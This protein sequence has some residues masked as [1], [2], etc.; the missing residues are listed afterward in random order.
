[1]VKHDLIK[2]VAAA[3]AV[4]LSLIPAAAQTP[5]G[6]SE[7]VPYRPRVFENKKDQKPAPASGPVVLETRPI[8]I[9]VSVLDANGRVVTDLQKQ[10][11]KVLSDGPEAQIVSVETRQEILNVVILIDVSASGE[12]E[13]DSVRRITSAMVDQFREKDRFMVAKFSDRLTIL[14]ELTSDRERVRSA[15]RKLNRNNGT[16]L[17][18]AVGDLYEKHLATVTGR[19]VVVLVTDG[20]DT[21]SRRSYSESLAIAERSNAAVYPIYLDTYESA[22]SGRS[23]RPTRLVGWES[24]VAAGISGAIASELVVPDKVKLRIREL[25]DVG[26]LYLND[27]VFLSGGRAIPAKD[28]STKM[29]SIADEVRQQYYVTF[30]PR[31]KSSIGQRRHLKVRVARP[32][33]AVLARGSYIVGSPPSATSPN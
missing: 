28:S 18:D 12:L 27:L 30:I 32:N 10:D 13:H 15:L 23:S 24:A 3:V 8:T 6:F 22:V 2:W 4:S 11:F 26:K 20:V 19:T 21:G 9:P 16:V 5:D 7:S 1:M 31:S 33:V 25:Y 29:L 17:Y 14:S